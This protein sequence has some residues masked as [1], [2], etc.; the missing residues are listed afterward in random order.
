M[1]LFSPKTPLFCRFPPQL[2]AGLSQTQPSL[3]NLQNNRLSPFS[4]TSNAIALVTGDTYS[5][6]NAE[7][8]GHKGSLCR[9][10][11]PACRDWGIWQEAPSSLHLPKSHFW[12][13]NPCNAVTLRASIP[14]ISGT[15][16]AARLESSWA[17]HPRP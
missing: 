1:T 9:R 2:S 7:K 15:S 16:L 11:R 8:M 12:C 17:F 3:Q 5:A 13:A 10:C 14:P 6:K 4:Q